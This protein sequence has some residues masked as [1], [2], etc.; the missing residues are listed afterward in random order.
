MRLLFVHQRYSFEQQSYIGPVDS[1]RV[2]RSMELD[3]KPPAAPGVYLFLHGPERKIMYVGMAHDLEKV[4]YRYQHL[5]GRQR[6]RDRAA[7]GEIDRVAW[8]TCSSRMTP[9]SLEQLAIRRYRPPWN[10][11]HNPDPRGARE[12]STLTAAEENWL[13][14]SAAKLDTI[15]N[16]LLKAGG[17]AETIPTRAGGS[18]SGT[19]AGPHGSP[20]PPLRG[21]R[22][23][24]SKSRIAAGVLALVLGTLGAHKFYL[25]RFG[26][27]VLYLVFSWTGIPTVLGIIEGIRYLV[28]TDETFAARYG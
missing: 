13:K 25:R 10:T 4:L 11:H 27:G 5:E 12:A 17:S 22:V 2:S 7:A 23:R 9:P 28:M 1:A 8:V 20:L 24:H 19:V 21:P 14:V 26:A 6:M 16:D 18:N 15:L 3:R